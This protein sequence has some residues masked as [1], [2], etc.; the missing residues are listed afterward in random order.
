MS[1]DPVAFSNTSAVDICSC[2]YLITCQALHSPTFRPHAHV[3]VEFKISFLG[4]FNHI[5]NGLKIVYIDDTIST[6]KSLVGFSDVT[7]I[8]RP[9]M[10]TE[11]NTLIVEI[12]NLSMEVNFMDSSDGLGRSKNNIGADIQ[13]SIVLAGIVD[14]VRGRIHHRTVFRGTV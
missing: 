14:S 11:F 9:V 12:K 10:Y 13:V 3:V 2:V 8:C 5:I 6:V 1:G 4:P 7:D